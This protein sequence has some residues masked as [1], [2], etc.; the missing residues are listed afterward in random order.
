MNQNYL[1]NHIRKYHDLIT[2]KHGEQIDS[3]LQEDGS[4]NMTY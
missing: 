1:L 4:L 3:N 2:Q